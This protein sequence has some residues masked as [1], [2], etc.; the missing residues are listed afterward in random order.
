MYQNTYF[1]YNPRSEKF[2]KATQFFWDVYANETQS[3]RDQPVWGYTLHHFGLK[4]ETLS[5]GLFQYVNNQEGGRMGGHIYDRN[6]DIEA[7]QFLASVRPEVCSKADNAHFDSN[8]EACLEK[9]RADGNMKKYMVC[10]K[11]K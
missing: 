2:Q 9:L 1:G 8:S 7:K 4:P 3:W 10:I 5:K 11:Q 6:T